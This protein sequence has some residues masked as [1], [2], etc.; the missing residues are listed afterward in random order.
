MGE[1]S[2]RWKIQ[3]RISNNER[4]KRERVGKK[5]KKKG[6]RTQREAHSNEW[7]GAVS[8]QGKL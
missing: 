2:G 8:S 6:S 1:M 3:G 4:G 7:L 5:K